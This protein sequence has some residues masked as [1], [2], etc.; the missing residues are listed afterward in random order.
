M[1]KSQQL[2]EEI[3]LS[4][5]SSSS[6]FPFFPQ[7]VG[8]ECFMQKRLQ[9]LLHGKQ[10]YKMLFEGTNRICGLGF[11]PGFNQEPQ[12]E[13]KQCSPVAFSLTH[14][15]SKGPEYKKKG[16]QRMMMRVTSTYPKSSREY[17]S[18]KKTVKS[19]SRR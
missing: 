9:V 10:S 1:S 13:K 2:L 18:A 5:F 17:M 3:F 11:K 12:T 4:H 16:C 19:S 14:T 15:N 7:H 6:Q 8:L